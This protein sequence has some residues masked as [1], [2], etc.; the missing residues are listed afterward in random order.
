MV[1]SYGLTNEGHAIGTGSAQRA[2]LSGMSNHTVELQLGK[3]TDTSFVVMDPDGKPLPGA[4]VEPVHFR[5]SLGYSLVPPEIVDRVSAETDKVGR[6]R[7]PNIPRKGFL[8]V[9]VVSKRFG[10]QQQ[11]LNDKADAPAERAIE[12]EAVGRVTG[13]VISDDPKWSRGVRFHLTTSGRGDAI[14]RTT[15]S[16]MVVTDDEG[17][18]EV[19]AL[20]DGELRIEGG[21]KQEAPVRAILPERQVITAN[22]EN[23]LAIRLVKGVVVQGRIRTKDRGDPIAGARISIRYGHFR[24]G[25]H[26]VSD[27]DGRFTARVLPGPVYQHVIAIPFGYALTQVGAPWNERFE[28][29]DDAIDFKLPVIE[30]VTTIKVAGR[31]IDQHGRP[32]VGVKLHGVKDGRR[33]GFSK[34]DKQGHFTMHLPKGM[35]MESYQSWFDDQPHALGV[36][37]ETPLLLQATLPDRNVP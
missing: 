36:K 10:T 7:L 16:A 24:Q 2:L 1:Q 35:K 28:V 15:G 3:A 18:F 31:L 8:N 13:R 20:T 9:K 27:K 5:S 34:T 30:L 11:R 26:V 12:L 6:A 33:Y 21:V 14:E 19:A 22:K 37:R 17:R 25:D 29:P 32:V 4:V 23:E